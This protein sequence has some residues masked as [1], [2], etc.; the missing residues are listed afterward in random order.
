MRQ[1]ANAYLMEREFLQL[2]SWMTRHSQKQGALLALATLDATDG[3]GGTALMT[4]ARNGKADCAETLLEGGADKDAA[5]NTATPPC[6]APPL[7]ATG[8]R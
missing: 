6:T 1:S 7:R 8:L 5:A 4:A 2:M 3:G